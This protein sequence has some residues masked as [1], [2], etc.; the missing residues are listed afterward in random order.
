ML[1]IVPKKEPQQG[2]PSLHKDPCFATYVKDIFM[3][4]VIDLVNKSGNDE[5]ILPLWFVSV[6][7][8]ECGY[9]F[10]TKTKMVSLNCNNG[11]CIVCFKQSHA[12]TQ[13]TV[14]KILLH[15]APTLKGCSQM[16]FK[17][18]HNNDRLTSRKD[19]WAELKD[20]KGL[21]LKNQFPRTYEKDPGNVE[22]ITRTH[23][24]V[25]TP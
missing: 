18:T 3:P 21:L 4:P 23:R 10:T 12:K 11:G 19:P 2:L 14:H 25:K 15:D 17:E 7:T 6:S 8:D 16:D 22:M 9:T 24:G 1:T 13:Q 20:L 5:A